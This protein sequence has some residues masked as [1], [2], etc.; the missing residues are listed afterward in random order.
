MS[1]LLQQEIDRVDKA[2]LAPSI[3]RENV[4]LLSP[5]GCVGLEVGVDTGAL[6]RR[7][8]DLDHFSVFHSVDKWD[9]HAHSEYQYRAVSRV[10]MYYEE[11]KVWR[12]TAQDFA[13]IIPNNS[14]GFIYIDC[15]AHTGQ[16]SGE[17]LSALWPKLEEGGIFAGDDYDKTKWPRTYSAVNDFAASVGR[18]ITVNDEFTGDATRTSDSYPTWWYRK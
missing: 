18:T 15:Y 17:V 3:G 10:L 16:D 7:F 8:L 14:L 1:D 4:A 2:I 13:A 9:D 12:M 6:S 11:S 5:E